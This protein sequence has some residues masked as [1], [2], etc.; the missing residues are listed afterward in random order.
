MADEL[1]NH[2]PDLV[3]QHQSF[4]K[5]SCAKESIHIPL[6]GLIYYHVKTMET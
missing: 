3:S 1:A 5:R 2:E 4:L 6:Q